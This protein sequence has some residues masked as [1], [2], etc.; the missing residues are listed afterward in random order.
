[1]PHHFCLFIMPCAAVPTVRRW[2]SLALHCPAPR[3]RQQWFGTLLGGGDD[4]TVAGRAGCGEP[5]TSVRLPWEE[6]DREHVGVLAAM[7]TTTTTICGLQAP[8]VRHGVVVLLVHRKSTVPCRAVLC[9]A[10]CPT[11]KHGDGEQT[12][13]VLPLSLS[14]WLVRMQVLMA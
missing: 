1:M 6:G 9:V 14:L 3:D 8:R 13:L 4:R 10:C 5:P 12:L 7:G 11:P 2:R